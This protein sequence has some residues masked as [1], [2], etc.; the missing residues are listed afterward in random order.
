MIGVS[1]V[2]VIILLILM[3][4]FTILVVLK[5]FL[6]KYS[7]TAKVKGF[8][9]FSD[10]MLKLPIHLNFFLLLRIESITFSF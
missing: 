4:P 3:M 1:I 6:S 2:F 8:F 10:I 7:F 5:F 9:T